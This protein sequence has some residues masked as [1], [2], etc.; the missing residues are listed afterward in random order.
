[1][2]QRWRRGHHHDGRYRNSGPG[3]RQ[4][5][6]AGCVDSPDSRH[7]RRR[8]CRSRSVNWRF[9]RADGNGREANTAGAAGMNDDPAASVCRPQ[10][11]STHAPTRADPTGSQLAAPRVD[12][13]SGQLSCARVSTPP[14]GQLGAAPVDATAA[15]STPRVST[16]R[17]AN[18]A[19]RESTPPDA[20]SA[21]RQST[22]REVNSAW[23]QST[24][25]EVDLVARLSTSRGPTWVCCLCRLCEGSTRAW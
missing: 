9:G 8:M 24:P 10:E 3:T 1:M 17:A 21:W 23:R 15:N 11:Q 5:G 20:N 19:L 18:A 25:R 7:T 12:P 6:D 22:V 4:H 2:Q 14:I 16:P 13:V